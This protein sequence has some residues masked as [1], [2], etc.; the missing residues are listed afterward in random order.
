VIAVLLGISSAL[1]YGFSDYFAGPASRRFSPALL[2][3]F[4]QIAQAVIILGVL[5]V[6]VRAMEPGS[7]AWGLAAGVLN[8]MA[9]IAYYE[10]LGR[11]TI[12]IVAP[13][14]STGAALPVIVTV[15]RGDAPSVAV[16]GGLVAIIVGILL[17]AASG[18]V[19]ESCS[20]A[21]CR[22]AMAPLRPPRSD[23]RPDRT[24]VVLSLVAAGAFGT[25][26]LLVDGGTAGR[27][28]ATT[29]WIAE[30][31]QLG[32]LATTAGVIL[33]RRSTWAFPRGSVARSLA[34]ITAL[35]LLA[36]MALIA[37]MGRG[38]VA[39]VGVL[40]SLAP[41]VT[42]ALAL[43]L[44]EERPSRQQGRG[45]GLAVLGTLVISAAQ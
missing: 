14:A 24:S 34:L 45:A 29:M 3:L 36:D 4:S 39:V 23:D 6:G 33:V 2:V 8:A 28:L 26:F 17:V 31:V 25:Y 13:I 9:L 1:G 10:A 20:E 21:L 35:N 16:I 37:G 12:S 27:E 30:G 32:A 5:A 42:V 44:G 41:V 15:L 19:D 40:T 18:P 7:L 11:G 38:S 43:V 22:G